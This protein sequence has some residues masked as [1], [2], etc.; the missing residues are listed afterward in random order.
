MPLWSPLPC[1][2]R[3]YRASEIL[4]WLLGMFLKCLSGCLHMP[5]LPRKPGRV[6]TVL[7]KQ[8]SLAGPVPGQ[9]L[10][11]ARRHTKRSPVGRAKVSL[12]K[13]FRLHFYTDI[14]V[15]QFKSVNTLKSC[16]TSHRNS[17]PQSDNHQVEV[18]LSESTHSSCHLRLRPITL[19][20]PKW[21]TEGDYGTRENPSSFFL[22]ESCYLNVNRANKLNR[23]L[24]LTQFMEII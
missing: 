19:S 2:S 10:P 16:K 22:S 6:G 15:L 3:S 12:G 8:L 13:W 18:G 24:K 5:Q 9:R 11:T 14:K 7:S 4:T 23:S 21:F 17:C 20:S 1:S